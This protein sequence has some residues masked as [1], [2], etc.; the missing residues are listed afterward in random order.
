MNNSQ[1]DQKDIA[2]TNMK[3]NKD[4]DWEDQSDEEESTYPAA[5]PH[6]SSLQLSDFTKVHGIPWASLKHNLANN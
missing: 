6:K 4:D 1:Q 2:D 5:R 3:D